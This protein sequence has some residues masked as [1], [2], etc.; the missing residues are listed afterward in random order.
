MVNTQSIAFW[1]D[2]SG[3]DRKI[4]LKKIIVKNNSF[5]IDAK[6]KLLLF[7][8]FISHLLPLCWR[9]L[10]KFGYIVEHTH[11]TVYQRPSIDG[12]WIYPQRFFNLFVVRFWGLGTERNLR[13]ELEIL[14][15]L[16]P[17]FLWLLRYDF[18][19][20]YTSQTLSLCVFKTRLESNYY[21]IWYL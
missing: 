13:T 1:A 8:T 18:S 14:G 11:T 4:L 21:Q 12:L 17:E 10:S 9:F 2:T 6:T 7:W 5:L 16:Y 19:C 20:H 15:L 3:F